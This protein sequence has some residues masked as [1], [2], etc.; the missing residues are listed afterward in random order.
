MVNPDG[1]GLD[2]YKIAVDNSGA[3]YSTFVFGNG[4]NV[5]MSDTV[6]ATGGSA[7]VII[8]L[9]SSGHFVR[10]QIYAG[11]VVICIA[12]LATDLYISYG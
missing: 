11:T 1:G 8:K 6:F 3:V 5:N 4:G 7:G 2:G 9:D 10:S 12:C